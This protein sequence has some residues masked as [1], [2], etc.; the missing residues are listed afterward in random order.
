M[1]NVKLLKKFAAAAAAVMLAGICAVS[2]SAASKTLVVYYSA[3]GNT[4]RVAKVIAQ[5]AGADLF[6]VTPA[7]PYTQADLNWN[8]SS[9]RVVRE[10]DDEK[11]R[12]VKL[13]ETSV[14]DWDSYDVVFVGY[15]IW[16][17]IAA[18]PL[19]SFVKAC[20]FTGKTV[21]PFC[22]SLSSGLGES[23]AL[24]EKAVRGGSWQKGRRFSSSVSDSEAAEWTRSVL[25]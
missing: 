3:T 12:D 21:I 10:H 5:T 19:S 17:G 15:P 13:A 20:D 8:D 22:T 24:L 25:K 4:E 2:A 7:Q 14:K 23:A 18:W 16:W 11:L 9:S 1:K 6:K